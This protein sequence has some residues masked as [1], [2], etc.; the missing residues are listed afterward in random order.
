[1]FFSPYS[2]NFSRRIRTK[3][4]AREPVFISYGQKLELNGFDGVERFFNEKDKVDYLNKELRQFVLDITGGSRILEISSPVPCLGTASELGGRVRT[5][6]FT[7]KTDKGEVSIF[8]KWTEDPIVE[9]ERF[10][11]ASG[12][13]IAPQCRDI[14]FGFIVSQEAKG[15]KLEE[16]ARA[17]DWMSDPGNYEL[18]AK[19]LGEMVAILESIR[20]SE[21]LEH[22]LIVEFRDEGFK[23]WAIDYEDAQ[24]SIG[25]IREGSGVMEDMEEPPLEVDYG[26]KGLVRDINPLKQQMEEWIAKLDVEESI[27][28]EMLEIFNRSYEQAS[29]NYP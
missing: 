14:G 9:I 16:L 28:H 23:I 10:L 3:P 7:V 19:Q 29:R 27:K 8:L 25:L 15:S 5:Y 1:L 13:K 21:S 6:K 24:V 4:P 22:N 18:L 17:V 26:F 11:E 20:Y 12:L 2:S